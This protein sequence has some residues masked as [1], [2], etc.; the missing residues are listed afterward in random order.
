MFIKSY[1]IHYIVQH[2]ESKMK[3]ISIMKEGTQVVSNISA[4]EELFLGS[5]I[6]IS[7]EEL[8]REIRKKEAGKPLYLTRYE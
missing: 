6:V 3:K 7:L 2:G 1:D 4:D 8:P 5:K